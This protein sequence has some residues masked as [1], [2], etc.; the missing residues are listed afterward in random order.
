MSGR[1]ESSD[2]CVDISFG[3]EKDWSYFDEKSNSPV[4]ILGIEIGFK[5]N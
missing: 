4:S 5:R 2:D 1:V 3:Y